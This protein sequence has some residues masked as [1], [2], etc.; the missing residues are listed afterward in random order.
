[1]YRLFIYFLGLDEWHLP[2]CYQNPHF[3]WKMPVPSQEC[4]SCFLV[5]PVIEMVE[6]LIGFVGFCGLFECA[7]VYG[8]IIITFNR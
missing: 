2:I 6:L 5:V 3:P 4:N 8:T 7:L 1:M